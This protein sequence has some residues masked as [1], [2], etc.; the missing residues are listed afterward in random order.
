MNQN[1]ETKDNNCIFYTSDYHF[2]MISLPYIS[3][4]LE[5]KKEVSIL[6]ENNLEETVNV[7]TTKI[8]LK[9]D[10]KRKILKINWKNNDESK[11]AEIKNNINQE[12]EVIVLIKG[13]Q[14]YINKM[15]K[16][17]NDISNNYKKI[18]IIDCYNFDEIKEDIGDIVGRYN[19]VIGTVG[20]KTI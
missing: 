16:N 15:H 5:N 7:L 3:K 10:N 4:E 2:E 6:T 18:K 14:D 1:K 9:D 12:K 8:N 11:L 19:N 13:K 17:L 20:K